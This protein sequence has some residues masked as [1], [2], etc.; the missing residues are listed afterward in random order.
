M[1]GGADSLALLALA[2]T[3]G[4]D[5]TAIHVD[6]GLREGSSAEAD[7]VRDIAHQFGASFRSLRV[8]LDDGPNLEARARAARFA[9][10]PPDVMTG[11]TS[12]DLVET[13]L[14]N[15]IRGAGLDGMGAM[16]RSGHHPILSL[17]RSQTHELCA[18]MG[19]TPVDDPMNRDP[20]FRRVR[21]RAE[22]LPLLG[23]IADRDVVSVIAR[24]ARIIADD[25]DLLDELSRPIDARDVKAL[26]RAPVALR[27]RALRRWLLESGVGDG[28][29]VA[30]DVIERAIAVVSGEARA[31]ELGQGWRLRR[32]SGQLHVDRP[33]LPPS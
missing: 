20:R 13:V 22:L 27:R 19:L 29:P 26:R 8:E 1:S 32:S 14:L 10:L 4:C 17:R 21:V 30:S 6:H 12:D 25:L 24:Q 7:V 11:H 31:T 23:A 18:S 28:Y 2:V 5:V 33:D 15:M 9:V 16:V 3:A